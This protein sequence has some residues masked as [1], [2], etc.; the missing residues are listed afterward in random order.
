MS[1]TQE[2]TAGTSVQKNKTERVPARGRLRQ[3]CCIP[4]PPRIRVSNM[5]VD[6]F[7]YYFLEN[8]LVILLYCFARKTQI[9]FTLFMPLLTLK[10]KRPRKVFI[11]SRHFF[12][13]S[14]SAYVVV[15]Q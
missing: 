5:A 11:N 7:I 9:F 12:L 10:T 14:R 13:V 4:N 8:N 3:K 6:R 15:V 2:T 1:C